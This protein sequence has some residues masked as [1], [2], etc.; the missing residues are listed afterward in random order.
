M[1][2]RGVRPGTHGEARQ[3]DIAPTIAALLGLPVPGAAE[4]RLLVEALDLDER[5]RAALVAEESRQKAALVH[6]CLA[7]IGEAATIEDPAVE[8]APLARLEAA[9]KAQEAAERSQRLPVLVGLLALALVF[10]GWLAATAPARLTAVAAAVLA[11]VATFHAL[12][13]ARGQRLSLSAI[14]YDEELEPYFHRITLFALLALGL[15][16]AVALAAAR[17]ETRRR[18]TVRCRVGLEAV[19][20]IALLL[21]LQAAAAHWREGLVM[22]WR[23]PDVGVVFPAFVRLTELQAV[24]FGVGLIPLLGWLFGRRRRREL[25]GEGGT[26]T[27]PAGPA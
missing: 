13:W 9:R 23:T 21:A 26:S 8:R 25:A 10:V 24:G 17:S 5:T 22:R 11:Y 27:R 16:V 14:N 15:A 2:G 7:A 3:V 4:G 19:A 20:A 12:L 6:A 1:A 18:F